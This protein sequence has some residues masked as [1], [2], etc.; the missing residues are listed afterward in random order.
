MDAIK[1]GRFI[2]ELRREKELTQEELAEKLNVTN[3]AVS[4]WETGSGFPDVDSMLALSSFFGVS[5]NEL[6]LG[7]RVAL[8]EHT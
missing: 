4:R 3:K 5:I 7:V 8:P 1:T 2:A 6:L